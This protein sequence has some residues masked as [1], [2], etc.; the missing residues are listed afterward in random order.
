MNPK[1]KKSSATKA[2]KI[3]QPIPLDITG[4]PVFPIV[5]GGL[6]VHSL[7]EVRQKF[8]VESPLYCITSAQ[9]VC[10]EVIHI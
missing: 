10:H 8:N 2:K 1:M 7:G 4:R 3:V 6:T 9:L 5:L